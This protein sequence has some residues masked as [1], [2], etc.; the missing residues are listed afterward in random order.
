MFLDIRNIDIETQPCS[1]RVV[2]ASLGN[3][4]CT[5]QSTTRFDLRYVL[6]SPSPA[7]TPYALPF[8]KKKKTQ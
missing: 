6:L 5:V 8:K 3:L 4:S 2:S 7:F 1:G